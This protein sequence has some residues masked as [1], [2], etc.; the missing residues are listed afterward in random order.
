MK[1]LF[2]AGK[3]R[4]VSCR[5]AKNMAALCAKCNYKIVAGRLR[6]QDFQTK[7]ERKFK[8]VTSSTQENC[9]DI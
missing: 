7:A 1:V 2:E 3:D 5:L 4:N 8:V 9:L 6:L